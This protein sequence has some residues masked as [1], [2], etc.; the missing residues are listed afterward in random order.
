[1]ESHCRP[2]ILCMGAAVKVTV[3]RVEYAGAD[4][5]GGAAHLQLQ[6]AHTARLMPQIVG[7]DSG[8]LGTIGAPIHYA[9]YPDRNPDGAVVDA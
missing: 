9:F 2:C 1:M 4:P 6:N 3:G 5:S 7:P 8:P